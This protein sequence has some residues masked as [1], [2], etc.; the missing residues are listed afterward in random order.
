MGLGYSGINIVCEQ[1]AGSL[2]VQGLKDADRVLAALHKIAMG[3]GVLSLVNSG[4]VLCFDKVEV[5]L[6]DLCPSEHPCCAWP[7]RAWRVQVGC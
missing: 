7:C 6:S 4:R 5:V 3:V 2:T 1:A